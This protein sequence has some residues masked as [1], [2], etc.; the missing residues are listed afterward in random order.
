MSGIGVCADFNRFRLEQ[1]QANRQWSVEKVIVNPYDL[2]VSPTPSA[3]NY[4]FNCMPVEQDVEMCRMRCMTCIRV[5]LLSE[6]NGKNMY[7][8]RE[9]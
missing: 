8:L 6:R 7:S 2:D 3:Q 1:Q 9:G 4:V 5:P